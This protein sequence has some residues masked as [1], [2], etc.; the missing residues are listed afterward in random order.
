MSKYIPFIYEMTP[1]EFPSVEKP[2][3]KYLSEDW[4]FCSRWKDLGGEIWA[5]TS[6]VLKHHGK[7]S[8]DLFNVEMQVRN[9]PPPSG[10]NLEKK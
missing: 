10:H 4:A 8:Y 2:F 1:E 6:L 9:E 5:D 7:I 3:K